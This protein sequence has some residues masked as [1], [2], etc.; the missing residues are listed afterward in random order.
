[1]GTPQYMSPEQARGDQVDAR[2]DIW[3]LGVVLYEMVSG[4][5]PFVGFTVSAVIK[6]ILENEVP[7]LFLTSADVATELES[8]TRTALAKRAE[9]RYRDVTE[10]LLSLNKL[11]RIIDSGRELTIEDQ[12]KNVY[13]DNYQSGGG[14]T[15]IRDE[16]KQPGLS[17]RVSVPVS[18]K[19]HSRRAINL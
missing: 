1:M 6:S 19:R 7:P 8:I 11:R 14:Y 13:P 5:P 17:D 15:T 16:Q 12:S 10:L 2:T 9:H 4:K 3:S 18:G